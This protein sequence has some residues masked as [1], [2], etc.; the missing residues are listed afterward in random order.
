[1]EVTEGIPQDY[2]LSKWGD[3][4]LRC[5]SFSNHR[6]Y[7]SDDRPFETLN[8]MQL[9]IPYKENEVRDKVRDAKDL[10]NK[11]VERIDKIKNNLES[12]KSKI[13]SQEPDEDKEPQ[14]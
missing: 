8:E 1:M 5:R 4:K 11:T 6:I 7:T 3:I 2:G 9:Y 10:V 12:I 14:N 13:M